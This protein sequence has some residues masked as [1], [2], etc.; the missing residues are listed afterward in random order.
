MYTMTFSETVDHHD[1]D[2][3]LVIYYIKPSTR[4]SAIYRGFDLHSGQT[5]EYNIGI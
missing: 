1:L 4:A 3:T 2:T 5:K